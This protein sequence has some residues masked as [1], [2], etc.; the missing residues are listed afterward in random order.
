MKPGRFAQ[1]R[2]LATMRA[3]V[4]P[5]SPSL[6]LRLFGATP[7]MKTVAPGLKLIPKI[8]RVITPEAL[9]FTL[10]LVTTAAGGGGLPPSE[11]DEPRQATVT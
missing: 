7:L 6:S 10:Q 4:P 11:T 9:L 3:N 8:S 5:A 1:V 2:P